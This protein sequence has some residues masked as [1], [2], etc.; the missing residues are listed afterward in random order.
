MLRSIAIL[1]A[2]AAGLFCQ[3]FE[4]ASVRVNNS[5]AF[6]FSTQTTPGRYTATNTP[7]RR[8]IR[9]AYQ[10]RAFQIQNLPAWDPAQRFD[11]NAK[12]AAA[13]G[14]ADLQ[15]ML[16]DLLATRFGLVLR[17]EMKEAAVYSLVVAKTGPRL[18]NRLDGAATDRR[19]NTSSGSF[20][21]DTSMAGLAG[22]LTA[23]LQSIV[24][25]KTGLEG[26]YSIDLKFVPEPPA[27][28][29]APPPAVNGTAGPSIFDAIEALGLKLERGKSMIPML[30]V[31]QA[32]KVPTEN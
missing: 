28:S 10:V 5:G 32:L 25:D 3:S 26:V 4:A 18:G 22:A 23:E 30:Y 21:G 11:I 29:P 19:F 2:T 13:T 24:T 17:R 15:A 20:K 9:D 6:D 7:L 1:M 8:L 27:D 31:E 16:R 12:M 14:P